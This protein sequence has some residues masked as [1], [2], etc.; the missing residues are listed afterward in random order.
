MTEEGK[1]SGS[2]YR[3]LLLAG[4]LAAAVW[5]TQTGKLT[6]YHSVHTVFAAQQD[7]C[8][9]QKNEASA[10]MLRDVR[11]AVGNDWFDDDMVLIPDTTD[12]WAMDVTYSVTRREDGALQIVD[13]HGRF[14][15]DMLVVLVGGELC[16]ADKDGLVA[17]EQMI[18]WQD[19]QYYAK[20]DGT[21]AVNEFCTM[22]NGKKVFA[23]KDGILAADKTRLQ[24]CTDVRL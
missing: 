11:A 7:P 17:K 12:R 5:F 1:K 24:K 6:G 23:E 20:K 22:K 18:T 21:I 9:I 10:A 4:L 2:L 13:S 16:Y 8:Q 19:Q 15:Y 14:V 3:Q